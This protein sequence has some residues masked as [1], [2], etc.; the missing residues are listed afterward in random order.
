[1]A[2]NRDKLLQMVEEGQLDAT[3]MV[4]DLLN[5]LSEDECVEFAHAHDIELNLTPDRVTEI[6][7]SAQRV[8]LTGFTVEI[9]EKLCTVAVQPDV[10]IFLQGDEA[11][12]FIAERDAISATYPELDEDDIELHLIEG[13][14]S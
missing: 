11:S 8:R 9:D 3:T 7:E 2:E 5:W 14:I 10:G 13:L 6:E 1:M 12:D 4:R